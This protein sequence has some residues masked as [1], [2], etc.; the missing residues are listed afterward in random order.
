[1][2]L[3]SKK[4]QKRYTSTCSNLLAQYKTAFK[5]IESE[6]RTVEDFCKRYKVYEYNLGCGS[7]DIITN[8]YFKN[9][10]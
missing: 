3:K 9:K 2:F 5:L 10:A 8:I 1:M 4:K 7:G 6:F